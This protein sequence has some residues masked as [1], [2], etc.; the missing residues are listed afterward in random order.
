MGDGTM[1][2]NRS[3][4]DAMRGCIGRPYNQYIQTLF[5]LRKQFLLSVYFD[6]G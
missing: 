3:W 4:A 2:Q 1:P 5:C 6:I